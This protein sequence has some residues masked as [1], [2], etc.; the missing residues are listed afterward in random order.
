M[1]AAITAGYFATLLGGIVIFGIQ[2][3]AI[4]SPTTTDFLEPTDV[5]MARQYWDA[6]SPPGLVL[7]IEPY[8][9]P[10]VFGVPTRSLQALYEPLTAWKNLV[11][12]PDPVRAASAG[13]DY[14]YMSGEW[15]AGLSAEQRSRLD[16]PC[17]ETLSEINEKSSPS[18]RWL[19]DIR[20]C[21]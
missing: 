8:R 18:S 14:I 7:D 17:A 3:L 10:L 11:D 13:Y 12:D 6:L 1:R 19:V 21:R 20:S 2:M 15:W 4:T 16:H 9:A 5:R